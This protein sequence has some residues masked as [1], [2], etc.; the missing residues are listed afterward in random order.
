VIRGLIPP[1]ADPFGA[2]VR[3]APSSIIQSALSN[4]GHHLQILAN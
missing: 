1:L 2:T 4:L 3:V